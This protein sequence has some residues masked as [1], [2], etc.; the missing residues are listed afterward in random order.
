MLERLLGGFRVERAPHSDVVAESLQRT[1]EFKDVTPRVPV[2]VWRPCET[3]APPEGFKYTALHLK[4]CLRV[5]TCGRDALV[6]EVVA[7]HYQINA[8]LE[9]RDSTA[10]AHDVGS[11]VLAVPTSCRVV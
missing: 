5:A 6:S 1:E 9:E 11:D 10:V 2:G 4:V 8:C 7:D 3:G